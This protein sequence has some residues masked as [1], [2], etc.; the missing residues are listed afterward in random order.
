[1]RIDTSRTPRRCAPGAAR[2]V[3]VLSVLL[4]GCSVVSVAPTW[5]LVKAAGTAT[6]V[7]MSTQAPTSAANTVHHGDAPVRQVC[8]EFNQRAQLAELVPAL[9]AAL[10]EQR[11]ASRV[12]EPGDG[13]R[14][15][16]VWLRYVATI[17]WDIPPMAS[18]YQP[19]LSELSLSL[20]RANGALMA[21]SS[22][23][24]GAGLGL[25]KWAATRRKVAPVVKA[26]VT[27]FDS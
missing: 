3:A 11:V 13:L 2:M 25:G 1:M 24:P 12:Y 7:A 26:V 18:D 9:Q 10:R 19:Y 6:S 8:I 5:E 20:H 23:D 14:E 16:D 27:G 21:S 4:G 22:Y 17:G 15:C